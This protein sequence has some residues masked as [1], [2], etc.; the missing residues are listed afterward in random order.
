[1]MSQ[2]QEQGSKLIMPFAGLKHVILPDA[3][4]KKRLNEHMRRVDLFETE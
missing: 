2:Q 1:M 4:T 3:R